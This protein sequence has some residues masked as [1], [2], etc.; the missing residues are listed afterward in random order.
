MKTPYVA[1]RF[2]EVKLALERAAAWGSA[3]P[4]LSAYFAGYLVVLLCGVVEDCAE[5]LVSI[6]VA[7][8]RDEGL[9]SFVRARVSATFRS[10]NKE[11]FT[12]IV[13]DFGP[14]YHKQFRTKIPEGA[15]DALDSI[16]FNK[17]AL[18]HG[19]TSKL[20][21]TLGDVADY[22]QRSSLVFDVL[23]EV[24]R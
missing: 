11:N 12:K 3:D 17:N 22:L 19:D 2:E 6:R 15:T 13:K 20:N 24:L 9:G 4:E 21:V 5:H 14:A 16:F 23:E 18:A 1:E 10:P 8:A 7:K